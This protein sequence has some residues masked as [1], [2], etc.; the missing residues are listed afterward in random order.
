MAKLPKIGSLRRLAK[1]LKR[2]RTQ[3]PRSRRK[4]ALGH[5]PAKNSATGGQALQRWHQR[6]LQNPNNSKYQ[7]VKWVG[8]GSQ[9]SITNNGQ[10]LHPAYQNP[11]NWQ[12]KLRKSPSGQRQWVPLDKNVHMG[13]KLSAVDYWEKGAAGHVNKHGVAKPKYQQRYKRYTTPGNK[14]AN[15]FQSPIHKEFM[16]D[17]ANY[18]FEWGPLNSSDGAKMKNARKTYKSLPKGESK[19]G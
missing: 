14:A 11:A 17:P 4:T 16:K 15:T 19:W 9:P 3:V 7:K 6:Q 8:N 18:R 1:G 13:H 2:G 12:V 10:K 5:T